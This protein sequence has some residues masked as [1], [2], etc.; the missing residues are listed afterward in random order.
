VNDTPHRGDTPANSSARNRKPDEK[1][2]RSNQ[3]ARNAAKLLA[4][5]KDGLENSPTLTQENP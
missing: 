4:V 3:K 2:N 5:R 1:L